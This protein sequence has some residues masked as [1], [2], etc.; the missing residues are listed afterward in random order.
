MFNL[1]M[2]VDR[3]KNFPSIELFRHGEV[4]TEREKS[5]IRRRQLF[6]ISKN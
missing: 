4:K 6:E 5:L 2:D 1:E 3:K